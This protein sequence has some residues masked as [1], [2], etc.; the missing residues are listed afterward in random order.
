MKRVMFVGDIH[1]SIDHMYSVACNWERQHNKQLDMIVQVGD[2]ETVRDENDLRFV[3][4][5]K[6]HRKLG[7]FHKFHSGKSKAPIPTYFIAGNHENFDFLD[8]HYPHGFEV[9]HN[10]HYLGRSGVKDF[11]EFTLAYLT[12]IENPKYFDRAK[13]FKPDGNGSLYSNKTRKRA[14]YCNRE[15]VEKLEEEGVGAD[16]L[17]AHL[18]P[19]NTMLSERSNIMDA[20]VRKLKPKHFFAGHLHRPIRMNIPVDDHVIGA[21]ILAHIGNKY[22]TEVLEFE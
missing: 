11:G 10:I 7:D 4:G 19:K 5:P 2:F 13:E 22:D 15:E 12:G 21:R 20:L 16:V 17:V 3:V 9:A 18:F 1:G 6:K 14:T 8:Q